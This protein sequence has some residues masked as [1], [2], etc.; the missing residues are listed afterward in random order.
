MKVEQKLTTTGQ[1]EVSWIDASL[2]WDPLKRQRIVQVLLPQ[3]DLWKPDIALMNGF[4]TV[5]AMGAK[6]MF[7]DVNYNGSCLWKPY[8]IMESVCKVDMTH[9]PYDTQTCVLKVNATTLIQYLTTCI[10]TC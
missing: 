8:Q 2:S 5:T 10:F 7:I 3:D 6:F 1:F 4:S 9:Y